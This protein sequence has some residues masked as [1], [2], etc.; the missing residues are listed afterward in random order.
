MKD[1]P[2]FYNNLDLTMA[3]CFKMLDR[4]V[5][6]RKSCFHSAVLA[7]V[8]K[9]NNPDARTV[10]LRGFDLKKLTISFHS[11]IRTNKVFQI[12][13]NPNVTMVFYDEKKKNK[14]RIN[15]IAKIKN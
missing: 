10:I 11:D 3:E 9:F 1:L 2:N 4:G 15:G 13:K 6:D 14:I 8:N 5:K 12:Q 7:S